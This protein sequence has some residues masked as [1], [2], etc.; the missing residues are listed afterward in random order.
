MKNSDN[1]PRFCR[2]CCYFKTPKCMAPE[3]VLAS[4]FACPDYW[5]LTNRL[6]VER[7]QHRR[8]EAFRKVVEGIEF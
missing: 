3:L 5:P 2:T 6:A 8:E 7:R 4:D 1:K